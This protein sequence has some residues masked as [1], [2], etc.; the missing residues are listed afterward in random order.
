MMADHDHHRQAAVWGLT[1]LS[2][3]YV[4]RTLVPAV[5]LFGCVVC[6][7][8]YVVLCCD[9]KLVTRSGTIGRGSAT[10]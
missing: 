1:P 3:S 6:G 5:L 4:S 8:G 7:A 9:L 2:E 10:G